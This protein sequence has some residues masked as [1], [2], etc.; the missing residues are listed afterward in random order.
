MGGRSL[1]EQFGPA[2][3]VERVWLLEQ[4]FE[5]ITMSGEGI[6]DFQLRQ[7]WQKTLIA[8]EQPQRLIAA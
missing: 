4:T 2:R 6:V 7:N 3:D 5:S 8:G 1:W